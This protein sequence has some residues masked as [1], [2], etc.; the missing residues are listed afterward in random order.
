MPNIAPFGSVSV[1]RLP[2][3]NDIFFKITFPLAMGNLPEM[4]VH[5]ASLTPSGV[6]QAA[7]STLT[8]GNII[9]GSFKLKFGADTTS[10]IPS[11]ASPDDVCSFLT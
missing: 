4:K 2:S 5:Y 6:A 3:G 11:D 7:V 10:S 8:E 9:G 1:S